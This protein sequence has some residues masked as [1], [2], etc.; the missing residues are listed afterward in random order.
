MKYT[1]PRGL[2]DILPDKVARWQ[3]A[4]STF[5]ETCHRYRYQEIRTPIFED[6]NLFTRA[7]GEETDIVSKEMYTFED[8]SGHSLTLRAEGTAPAVRAYIEN[9]LWGQDRER[10][11]KLYYIGPIFRYDRPQAGRYRQHH[12]CGIEAIGS[13]NPAVD[14]EVIDLALGFYGALGIGEVELRLNSVGCPDCAPGYLEALK[15]AVRPHIGEMCGDCQR[16]FDANPMRILDCKNEVCKSVTEQAPKM[17]SILCDDCSRHFSGV[18]R[19]LA[20]LRIEYVI[21][22]RI[23]RGLDYYT[24]TAF[25]FKATGLGAQDSIGGG[26]RYDGLVEQ[27]GGRATPGVGL[28]M[29]LERILLVRE[30]M[31]SGEETTPRHGTMIVALGERAWDQG[32]ELAGAL[33]DAG[34]EVD[35]DYRQRSLRAQL[36]AAD[37][38]GFAHAVILG[39]DE[40]DRGVATLRDMESSEQTEVPLEQLQA[41]LSSG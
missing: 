12:Q 24:K 18:C 2:Q 36:R 39:D 22:P 16:R 34:L 11:V 35:L 32:V 17:L 4:E 26:G 30:S 20:A 38:D 33:R 3:H 25:E 10:L 41:A 14:A 15:E 23:V 31:E 37:A 7:V 6:T 21:D 8:R 19:H 27:C 13:A 28:G 40:L 29:G 9:N 1:R 5:R